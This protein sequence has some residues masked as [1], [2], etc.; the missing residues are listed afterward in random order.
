M[1]MA[2]MAVTNTPDSV[3]GQPI[4]SDIIP[5]R[6]RPKVLNNAS[7]DTTSA[8][9][10]ALI[11]AMFCAMPEAWDMAIIPRTAPKNSMSSIT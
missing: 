8:A 10:F 1:A 7:T 5:A 6:I 9:F 2:A 3:L 11:P 4:W